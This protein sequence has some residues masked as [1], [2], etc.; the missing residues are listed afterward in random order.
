MVHLQGRYNFPARLM[1]PSPLGDM[2]ILLPQRP[3]FLQSVAPVTQ[4]DGA[5]VH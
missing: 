5:I 3:V 1:L 4:A 2:A